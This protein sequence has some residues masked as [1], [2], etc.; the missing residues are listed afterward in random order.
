MLFKNITNYLLLALAHSLL[1][2]S[3]YSIT[4]DQSYI[5]DKYSV[6]KTNITTARKPHNVHTLSSRQIYD[7]NTFTKSCVKL[8]KSSVSCGLRPNTDKVQ[9]YL[10][11]FNNSEFKNSK[12]FQNYSNHTDA[13]NS[14]SYLATRGICNKSEQV[15][16]SIIKKNNKYQVLTDYFLENKTN[17]R[18]IQNTYYKQLD[19]N[20]LVNMLQKTGLCN[21]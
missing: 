7:L 14:I 2:S 10:N 11:C 21:A 5:S 15:K 19:A 13:L 18:F 16:C 17:T 9:V 3:T 8:K 1:V 12:L 4:I 6:Q 20:I